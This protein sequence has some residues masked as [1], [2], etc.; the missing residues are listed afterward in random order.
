MEKCFSEDTPRQHSFLTELEK[1]FC[2][3]G[4]VSLG[5]RQIGKQKFKNLF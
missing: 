3:R 5:T 4:E 2:A 1:S